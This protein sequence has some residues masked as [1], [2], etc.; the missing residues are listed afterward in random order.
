[1]AGRLRL[2]MAYFNELQA[3]SQFASDLDAST[4]AQL[5]RGARLVELLKQPQYQ[6]LAVEDQ[7][8]IIWVGT[9]GYFDEIPVPAI[10]RAAKEYL[11]F[12]HNRH[13]EITQTI[14]EKQ[15]LDDALTEMMKAAVL[16]FKAE[17][18]A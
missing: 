6:P 1:V 13:P 7:V 2:D 14:I 11:E 3:F 12:V 4:K 5:N 9:N 15:A 8:V 18:R 17:F 10:T 16:E